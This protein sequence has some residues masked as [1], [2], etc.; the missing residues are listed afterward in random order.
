[1]AKQLAVSKA[2]IER[3]QVGASGQPTDF[4]A[5]GSVKRGSFCSLSARWNRKDVNPMMIHIQK[6][7][8]LVMEISHVKAVRPPATYTVSLSVRD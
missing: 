4:Q 7:E 3:S 5:Y 6:N 1:M 2:Q 8:A